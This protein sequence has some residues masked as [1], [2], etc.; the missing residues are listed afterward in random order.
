MKDQEHYTVQ[1]LFSELRRFEDEL[2]KAGKQEN[3][4]RTYV[5]RSA[6][7]VRWLAGDY[8]PNA[9]DRHRR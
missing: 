1:E 4:V 8:M 3:T 5:D 6:I 7:F 9:G 2:R